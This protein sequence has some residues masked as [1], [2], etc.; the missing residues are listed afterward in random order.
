[1]HD[2]ITDAPIGSG[3]APTPSVGARWRVAAETALPF[4]VVG[5]L[6]ETVAHAGLFPPRLFPPLEDVAAALVRLTVAGIL[7]HH[8]AETLLRLLA[9]FALAAVAGVVLASPWDARAWPRTS[10]C[11]W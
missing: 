2:V 7:P 10:R 8:A 3:P 9:G 11:R 6:W 1:M 5:I 4:L